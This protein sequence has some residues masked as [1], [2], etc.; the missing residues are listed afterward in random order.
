MTEL[1]WMVIH[2]PTNSGGSTWST[3]PTHH[4][5]LK[6][7]ADAICADFTARGHHQEYAIVSHEA[8]RWL[9]K[10]KTEGYDIVT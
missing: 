9:A 1:R 3:M 5:L 4:D 2:R 8:G 10:A 6:E 7:A